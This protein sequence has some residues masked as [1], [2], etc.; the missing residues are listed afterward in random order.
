MEPGKRGIDMV[1]QNYAIFPNFSVRKDEELGLKY[2]NMSKDKMHE[3]DDKFMKLVHV[4]TYAGRMLEQ[5]FGEQQ[6]RIALARAL[7]IEPDILLMDESC[8]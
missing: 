3:E 6:P 4:D 8:F 1:F 2:K 5:L 7:I